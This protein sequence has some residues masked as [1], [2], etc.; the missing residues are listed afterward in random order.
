M[1]DAFR[2]I[3]RYFHGSI[4][5]MLGQTAIIEVILLGADGVVISPRY[6][7]IGEGVTGVREAR[8]PSTRP[9]RPARCSMR[10]K[11]SAAPM[12]VLILY[13]EER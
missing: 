4:L 7:Q 13:R 10:H 3:N 6:L 1:T 9:K 11:I 2:E 12:H 5:L 8:A